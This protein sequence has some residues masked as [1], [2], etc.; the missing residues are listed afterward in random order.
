MAIVTGLREQLAMRRRPSMPPSP[1]TSTSRSSGGK[2]VVRR[3]RAK[4]E[5]T[6]TADLERRLKERFAPIDLIDALADTEHWLDWTRHF[7]PVSGFDAKVDRPRE[8]YLATVFCYGCKLGP[9]QAARA[10]KG[11]GPAAARLRQPA[12]RH[13]GGARRGDHHRHRRLRRV[14][15]AAALGIRA[16]GVG[17]RHAMGPSPAEPDVRVPHPLRGLRRHRLLPGLG[18]LHRAVLALHGLRR[19]GGQLNPGLRR[20][21]TSR[22]SSPTRSTPTPRARVRRSSAWPTCSASG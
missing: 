4:P 6:G 8:R 14:P 22:R 12:P 17:R 19:L 7:G 2:P 11:A 18:H 3:L 5:A 1:P 10:M 21:R 13:R 9:S 16:F 15:S 20:P